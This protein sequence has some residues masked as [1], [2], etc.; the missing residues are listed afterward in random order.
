LTALSLFWSGPWILLVLTFYSAAILSLVVHNADI[1]HWSPETALK[2]GTRYAAIFM[3]LCLKIWHGQEFNGLEN[4]PVSGGALIVWY[5]GPLPSDYIGLIAEI[6]I[7]DNRTI[8][9]I[10]DKVLKKVPYGEIFF[11]KLGVNTGGRETAVKL[12]QEGKLL[13]VSPGGSRE[14]LFSEHYEIIWGKRA[15]FAKVALEA[16]VPIRPV[17]TQNIREAYTYMR[18]FTLVWR[19][20]YEAMRLPI[21]PIW[22]GYPVKLI[23]HI[24][25]PILPTSLDT[26]ETLREKTKQNIQDLVDRYQSKNPSVTKALIQRIYQGKKINKGDN[27]DTVV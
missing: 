25:E 10:V 24:G 11:E 4:I 12:L 13:G 27:F 14:A 1:F 16:N 6:Q 21:V 15:G 8:N 17:F 3:K 20:V 26:P 22:G 2:L 7:R 23:T 19:Y 5:H 18:S 9:S